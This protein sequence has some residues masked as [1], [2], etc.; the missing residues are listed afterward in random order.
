MSRI[1]ELA[2]TVTTE[3]VTES[4]TAEVAIALIIVAAVV[5]A[6]GLIL[7]R[8]VYAGAALRGAAIAIALAGLA[9][10][11]REHGWLTGWDQPVTSWFTGHR[12]PALDTAAV[13]VTDLGSPVATAALAIVAGALLAWRTQS[14]RPAII[15]IGTV[16][17]AAAASTGLKLL[18]ARD[19]PPTAIQLVTETDYS[20]PSGHVTGTAALLG[21]TAVIVT[22]GRSRS[23]RAAAAGI[24]A[25]AVGVVATT[26]LY[27]GVHWLTDVVAGALLAALFI[28]A[29]TVVMQV[30]RGTTAV[31]ADLRSAAADSTAPSAP[32]IDS[33]HGGFGG[34]ARSTEP[35][36]H[37]AGDAG[38]PIQHSSSAPGAPPV[39][40]SEGTST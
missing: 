25:V 33:V 39:A 18:L 19:R 40:V 34:A 32:D 27:L 11:V 4:A 2:R 15:L 13:V 12:T 35:D 7:M 28:T 10:H 17:A 21:I 24:V 37:L 14:P 38:C 22:V 8:R 16:G 20:F 26:R 5:F 31:D 9:V 29:G 30:T 1:V 36:R 23:A 6:A 3:A